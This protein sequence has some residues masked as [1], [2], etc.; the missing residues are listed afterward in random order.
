MGL[1]IFAKPRKRGF[2][3]L[4][5][6][7]LTF[8]A[9]KE[10]GQPDT[11]KMIELIGNFIAIDKYFAIFYYLYSVNLRI[12]KDILAKALINAHLR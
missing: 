12:D 10:L 7:I 11:S 1:S 2:Y 4:L 3:I 9:C 8:I 5:Y 6:W